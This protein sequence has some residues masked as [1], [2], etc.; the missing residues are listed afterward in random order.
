MHII[1]I[2]LIFTLILIGAIS[3]YIHIDM[4]IFVIAIL[5]A[6]SN[7][8]LYMNYRLKKEVKEK[9]QAKERLKA[10]N[11]TLELRINHELKRRE[12]QDKVLEQ[13]AKMA[14]MGEMMDAVAH[15][16]KQPLNAITLYESLLKSDFQDGIV[17]QEYINNFL[18]NTT[19]QINHMVNTLDEFRKFFRDN[20][21]IEKVNIKRCIES[22]QRLIKDDFLKNHIT[23]DVNVDNDIEVNIKENE[24]KHLILNIVNNSKDAF[25]ENDIKKRI[26]KITST[27]IDKNQILIEFEDNA[28]GIPESIIDDIFKPNVTT[29]SADKGTGIGLYMSMQIA[30]KNHGDLRVR[31]SED[32]A[33]FSLLLPLA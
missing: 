23:I 6:I 28:G 24:L 1:L 17:D 4:S 13:Q 31:N 30:N 21:N 19:M 3:Y 8:V 27:H 32:G 14:A 15:Q 18:D 11:E 12:E 20:Q 7:A 16:W 29:K 33:I 22:L 9:F 5:I 2:I 25:N 10:L 26:I